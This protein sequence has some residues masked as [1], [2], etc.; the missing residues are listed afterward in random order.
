L[1]FWHTVC[2]LKLKLFVLSPLT[3]DCTVDYM[4][5]TLRTVV[6]FTG[7]GL[8]S[9]EKIQIKLKPAPPNTGILFTRVDL[10]GRPTVKATI[11]NVVDTTLATTIAENGCRVATVE[12]LLAGFFGLG[13]DNAVVELNGPEVPIMDGSS[14]P[15]VFLIRSAGITEQDAPKRFVVMKKVLKIQD[16]NRFIHVCPSRELKITYRIDFQHPLLKDQNYEIS[17]SGKNFTREISRAR[18]FG[19]LKDVQAMKALGLAKGGSLDNAIVMDDFRV[20][21]EDGLRFKDEFVRHKILDFV[22]DL[23]MVGSPV[24][25]HFVVEKSGHFLNHCMLRRL[26]DGRRNWTDLTFETLDECSNNGVRIP[27]FGVPEPLVA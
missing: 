15:F 13:V 3:G 20:L 17:F 9:G 6:G 1:L 18:T 21:N 12:H 14:G 7:I 23:A 2:L 26:M 22:G 4:Q 10:K 11:R 24:I 5:R 27:T 25:A 19:F 8:H 16:G